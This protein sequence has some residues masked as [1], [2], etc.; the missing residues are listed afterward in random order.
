MRNQPTRIQPQR[1]RSCSSLY[2]KRS[3]NLE[4]DAAAAAVPNDAAA[5]T[6]IDDTV[7]DVADAV[8]VTVMNGTAVDAAVDAVADAA[9]VATANALADALADALAVAPDRST[10]GDSAV[11]VPAAFATTTIHDAQLPSSYSQVLETIQGSPMIVRTPH[12]SGPDWDGNLYHGQVDTVTPNTVRTMGMP[13]TTLQTPN[14]PCQK[15][16][17]FEI[18]TM[19]TD[20]KVVVDSNS[21]ALQN[22]LAVNLS[23]QPTARIS[24][25]PSPSP[26]PPTM[27][28]TPTCLPSTHSVITPP[29]D[30]SFHVPRR[31]FPA[32]RAPG[33]QNTPL[34][35]QNRFS[36]LPIDNDAPDHQEHHVE[37]HHPLHR[38]STASVEEAQRRERRRPVI[39]CTENHLNNFQPVRPGSAAYSKAAQ[40]GRRV[41]VLSDSMMQRIRKPEFYAN[42][43]G[44]G[45]IKTFPGANANYL[46]HHS[47]PFLIEEC[48]NTLVVHGG[49]NDLRN[50]NKS[51]EDIANDLI[52]LGNTAKSFGVEHVLISDIVIRKDGVHIDR[53]RKE[54][55]SILKDKCSFNNFIYINNGNIGL[56][57]INDSDRVH[58]EEPGSVKLANNVL[59]SLHNLH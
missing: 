12:A 25:S 18:M 53:K 44:W 16:V 21:Q 17:L 10:S 26:P 48:P 24:P 31:T 14:H 9:S 8:A 23:S 1:S 5:V 38:R 54:V 6:A 36:N 50:R 40:R 29:V 49:T 32:G 19:M 28:P 59:R 37:R 35:T 51:A 52:K 57:D 56:D 15:S 45:N 47:L 20:L 55:N 33:V 27:C 22:L 43:D 42:M 11:P 7:A 3:L 46:H 2:N 4:P 13:P 58:M 39:C 41:F 34:P 30:N